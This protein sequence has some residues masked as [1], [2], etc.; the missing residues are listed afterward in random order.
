MKVEMFHT[1]YQHIEAIQTTV[2][3]VPAIVVE[4]IDFHTKIEDSR[5]NNVD[6]KFDVP[7]EAID[8]KYDHNFDERFWLDE[9]NVTLSEGTTSR[10]E[11]TL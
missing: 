9:P 6:N 8:T 2:I 4:N 3:K 7:I 10:C 5:M 11:F 1:F